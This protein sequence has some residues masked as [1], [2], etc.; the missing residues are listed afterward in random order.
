VAAFHRRH[1]AG[2]GLVDADDFELLTLVRSPAEAREAILRFYRGY[3]SQRRVGA[4]LACASREPAGERAREPRRA[5]P[6]R[7]RPGRA[8]ASDPLPEECDEPELA[9][10]PRLRLRR[11]LRPPGG[12]PAADC[13]LGKRLARRRPPQ[14][15]LEREPEL[16]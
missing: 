2:A 11:A 6:G 3:H 14:R 4:R 13:G 1:L 8:R 16:E 12:A 9:A 7:D 10:F 5:A 15:P